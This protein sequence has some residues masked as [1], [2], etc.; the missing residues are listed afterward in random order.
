MPSAVPLEGR[1]CIDIGAAVSKTAFRIT[2]A[3]LLAPAIDPSFS[4][5]LGSFND[6][7]DVVSLAEE[8]VPVVESTDLTLGE[9]LPFRPDVFRLQRCLRQRTRGVVTGKYYGH[10]C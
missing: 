8:G 4:H 3:S 1:E 7:D 9:V 2:L 5:V 6:T 10:D